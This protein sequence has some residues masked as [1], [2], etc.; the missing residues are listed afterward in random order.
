MG[1]FQQQTVNVY[2]RVNHQKDVL[3]CW[4]ATSPVMFNILQIGL[5]PRGVP[6]KIIH[7]H[8]VSSLKKCTDKP[9]SYCCSLAQV[10]SV[11]QFFSFPGI[12]KSGN[13]KCLLPQFGGWI[14]NQLFCYGFTSYFAMG[15]SWFWT[16]Q[17]SNARHG[18]PHGLLPL[19]CCLGPWEPHQT[20][21]RALDTSNL[22]PIFA[23]NP[24]GIG[25]RITSSVG[26]WPLITRSSHGLIFED[27]N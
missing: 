24:C 20:A 18:L 7:S 26:T 10:T 21:G 4:V 6:G 16:C 15:S 14:L 11:G 25:Y 19:H 27:Q 8:P 3:E 5:S 23:L 1:H 22:V 17:V 13:V 9:S 2:Q 12:Q